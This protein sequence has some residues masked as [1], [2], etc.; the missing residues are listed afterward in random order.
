MDVKCPLQAQPVSV[1]SQQIGCV[2]RLWKFRRWVLARGSRSVGIGLAR[3]LV[4]IFLPL[5]TPCIAPCFLVYHEVTW[6]AAPCL[7]I[8]KDGTHWNHDSKR[9]HEL[10]LSSMVTTYLLCFVKLNYWC[11]KKEGNHCIRGTR[12][13]ENNNKIRGLE[14]IFTIYLLHSCICL[15]RVG[16]GAPA[17]TAE[18]K[19]KCLK[20]EFGT[21][22]WLLKILFLYLIIL[23]YL[24]NHNW[25]ITRVI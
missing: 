23:L 10:L 15:E 1:W 20:G 7:S 17:M 22:E 8:M 25:M 2:G 11:L 5:A 12:K 19:S 14:A 3:I 9:I 6:D 4:G 21:R 16:P 18:S 24:N 13:G